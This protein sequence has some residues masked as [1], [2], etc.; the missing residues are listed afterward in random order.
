M[1]HRS[2]LLRLSVVQADY[3]LSALTLFGNTFGSSKLSN[4]S[5]DQCKLTALELSLT[6]ILV[7]IRELTMVTGTIHALCIS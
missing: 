5:H 2:Q 6:S 4:T 1:S 3:R 7:T